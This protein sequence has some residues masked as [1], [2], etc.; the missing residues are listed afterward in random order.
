MDSS[1]R[2]EDD[3]VQLSGDLLR[4][5]LDK[6]DL[7]SEAMMWKSPPRG[8]NIYVLE[9]VHVNGSLFQHLRLQS[10]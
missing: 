1:R 9:A 5:A 6:L 7:L 10:T 8:I 3:D 2:I 4:V